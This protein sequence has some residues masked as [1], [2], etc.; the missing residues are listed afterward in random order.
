MITKFVTLNGSKIKMVS[1]D[2]GA[3]WLN[4]QVTPLA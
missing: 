3:T 1:C 4:T 2:N